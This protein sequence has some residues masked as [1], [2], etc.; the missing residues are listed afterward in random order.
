M[1]ELS[2]SNNRI[3]SVP[4][5]IR[6]LENLKYLYISKNKIKIL[7]KLSKQLSFIII[8]DNPT[9][10]VSIPNKWLTYIEYKEYYKKQTDYIRNNTIK[11]HYF[12][13]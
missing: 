4:S 12:F 13:N 11:S 9:Y 3:K 1:K 5:E 8:H 2:L 10:P 6:Q 7:P